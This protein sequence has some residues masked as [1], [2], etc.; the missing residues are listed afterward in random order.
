MS[1]SV[2]WLPIQATMFLASLFAISASTVVGAGIEVI[3]S[4]VGPKADVGIDGRTVSIMRD[5]KL[6]ED[7]SWWSTTLALDN[8]DPNNDYIHVRGQGNA[9]SD[10]VVREG[11][12]SLTSFP[13]VTGLIDIISPTLIPSVSNNG[14]V[15][16]Y[17]KNKTAGEP[18]GFIYKYDGSVSIVAGQDQLVPAPGYGTGDET[19]GVI[20]H[21]PNMLANGQVAFIANGTG[22]SLP[23]T[24]DDV[25]LTADGTV[26]AGQQTGATVYG[27]VP[28]D[29]PLA[30]F[31]SEDYFMSEDGSTFLF[32]GDT[33][34]SSS[35]DDVVVYGAIGTAGTVVLQEGVTP[36]AGDFY[37]E[38]YQVALA[39]NGDWYASG[40]TTDNTHVT[41]RNGQVLEQEGML[42]P[43]GHLY[44]SVSFGAIDGNSSGN[45]ISLWDTD[46]PDS[47]T[48]EI[49][50]YNGSTVLL[51]E[52]DEVMLDMGNGPEAY[53]INEFWN[54]AAE[55]G[56]DGYVYTMVTLGDPLTGANNG[57]AFI[58]L[59]AV[60]E[61]GSIALV[62]GG[63]IVAL[64]SSIRRRFAVAK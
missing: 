62:A 27:A 28:N 45:Y 17:I 21:S 25:A 3:V 23:T 51:T 5:F 60:P 32:Q 59:R 24:E 18:D 50:V 47:T 39:G 20:M 9:V 22:G 13:G 8:S 29:A 49:L 64:G 6:S 52:G 14:S 2:K 34:A 31:D 57:N 12:A 55:I 63:L 40:D 30:I 11:V 10:I 56:D 33:T 35:F 48:D 26:L 46:K 58:R 53:L 43:N 15:A 1:R 16:G 42:A 38:S 19:Y 44:T 7:G 37:D 36:I 61:P 54:F 4:T 41:I